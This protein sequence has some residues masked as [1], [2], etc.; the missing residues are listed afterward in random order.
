MIT[1]NDLIVAICNLKETDDREFIH[2]LYHELKYD[3]EE[4]FMRLTRNMFDEKIS[5]KE[6]IRVI[7]KN[8]TI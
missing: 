5:L 3:L 4:R 1:K 6:R 2:H 7:N 8:D